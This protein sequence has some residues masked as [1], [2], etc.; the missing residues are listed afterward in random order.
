M[1]RRLRDTEEVPQYLLEQSELL[2]PVS[3][4]ASEASWELAGDPA[5]G[6]QA[7]IAEQAVRPDLDRRVGGRARRP[8]RRGNQRA[9]ELRKLLRPLVRGQ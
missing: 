1:S 8:V 6:W 2:R 7:A 9:R 4:S 5:A 3:A